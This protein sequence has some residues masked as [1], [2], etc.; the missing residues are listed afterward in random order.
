MRL[1]IINQ[2]SPAAGTAGSSNF[3]SVKFQSQDH[4]HNQSG[5]PAAFT[6]SNSRSVKTV[7][8]SAAATSNGHVWY[9]ATIYPHWND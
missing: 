8:Q 4:F 9:D 1:Q 5:E 3:Q 6:M 2:L 7:L